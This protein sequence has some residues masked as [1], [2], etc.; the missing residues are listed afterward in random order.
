MTRMLSAPPNWLR[1][2]ILA[3]TSLAMFGNYYV[4]DSIGPVADSLQ[5]QLG[6][7]DT[8]IGTL[9]AIY[10]LPNIVMVLFG[11]MI[12]DRYGARL[13]ILCFTVVC[14]LGSLLTAIGGDFYV[15]AAGRLLF[16]LGAE[17]MIVAIST[18]LGQWFAGS[19]LGFAFGLNLSIARA[20]S[21]AADM[22]PS[23]AKPLYDKGWQPPLWFAFALMACSLVAA[24]AY[25][26]LDRRAERVHTLA[27]VKPSERI[28]WSDLFR[29]NLSYWYVVILCVTFY[30]VILPFRSTFAIK[31][32]QHSF[33]MDLE[34]AS[35]MNSHVF[36]AAIFATPLF[37]WV[38]DRFGRRALFMVFG[39]LLLPLCFFIMGGT[40]LSLWYATVMFGISFSLV[41]AVMWPAVPLLVEERRLGTAFGLMTMLQN[42]GLTACN[43]GAGYINDHSDASASNPAG[44]LPMLWF[45]GLLSLAGFIF[46]VLLRL[47]ESGPKGHGLELRERV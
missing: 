14:V 26:Y 23:F 6:F 8:Q 36:F 33:G 40:H 18:A 21:Y 4:Y 47:R 32:F 10:S 31:Y 24:I 44:Y 7:T 30:S 12:V 39:S 46:A 3:L 9:N 5:K 11:G 13:A 45:F 17:S 34:T 41:P 37:G 27:H 29:F 1:W 42:M 25:W 16:G 19:I 35:T 38:A 15:M 22:S 20:G 28:V 43:F 2:T